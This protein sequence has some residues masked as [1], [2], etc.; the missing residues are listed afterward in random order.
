MSLQD[1]DELITAIEPTLGASFALLTDDGLEAAANAVVNEL[2]V[3]LPISNQQLEYWMVERGKRHCL[4][5]LTIE[6]AHKF[7]YKNAHLQN[8][9]QNYEKLISLMDKIFADAVDANPSLFPD[10]G[11]Y[12]SD[13]EAFMKL[14]GPGFV[15]EDGTGI[16]LTYLDDLTSE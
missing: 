12:T 1:T 14:I 4:M 10:M 5:I 2:G 15:Y 9:F 3:S 16:E 6:A 11:I 13:G 8:R 7:R